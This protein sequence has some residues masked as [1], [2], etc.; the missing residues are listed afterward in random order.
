MVSGIR[1]VLG[2]RPGRRIR[3]LMCVFESLEMRSAW[4]SWLFAGCL[5]RLRLFVGFSYSLEH[6]GEK[7]NF[8]EGFRSQ[9]RFDAGSADLQ[10]DFPHV[11]NMCL[12]KLPCTGYDMREEDLRPQILK[13]TCLQPPQTWVSRSPSASFLKYTRDGGIEVRGP[14]TPMCYKELSHGQKSCK[15]DHV[16][17]IWDPC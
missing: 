5:L 9:P 13:E 8:Q 11:S 12:G 16:E 1:P 6:R 17:I 14:K 7:F 2:I 3:M 4:T 15:K 10:L